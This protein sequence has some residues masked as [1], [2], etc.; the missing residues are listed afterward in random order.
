MK[1]KK[2][3]KTVNICV[4]DYNEYR[5][6]H[7]MQRLFN[8]LVAEIIKSAEN[9]WIIKSLYNSLGDRLQ[10]KLLKLQKCKNAPSG[11]AGLLSEHI[12]HNVKIELTKIT[13]LITCGNIAKIRIIKEFTWTVENEQYTKLKSLKHD[14]A[15]ESK[16]FSFCLN[17][18]NIT[19]C[20]IMERTSLSR[21]EL[22]VVGLKSISLRTPLSVSWSFSVKEIDFSVE[23]RTE[24]FEYDQV[25]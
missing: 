14:D 4:K 2:T 25:V 5:I 11:L 18:E 24:H 1:T 10:N 21:P 16:R 6:P 8:H 3:I 17:E 13:N 9:I 15:I 23:E 19:F 7:Y 20:G 12:D 22:C